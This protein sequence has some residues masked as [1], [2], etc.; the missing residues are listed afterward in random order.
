MRLPETPT[1]IFAANDAFALGVLKAA[2]EL[3][4]RVPQDVAIIGFDDADYAPYVGLTTISQ[5][6][7]ES[8]RLAVDL[9]LSVLAEPERFTRHIQLPLRV[10]PR[11]T[12]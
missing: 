2:R 3:G 6:L 11:E 10:M 8:G 5:S 9:L 12:A 4:L 7:E 1:A